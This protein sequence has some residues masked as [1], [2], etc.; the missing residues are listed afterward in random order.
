M[1]IR[2]SNAAVQ[3]N[4]RFTGRPQRQGADRVLARTETG[5]RCSGRPV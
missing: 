2:E 5:L 3:P 1:A 4:F